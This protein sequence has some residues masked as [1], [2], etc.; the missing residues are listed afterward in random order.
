MMLKD[1]FMNFALLLHDALCPLNVFLLR[2][3]AAIYI[4]FHVLILCRCLDVAVVV[5]FDDI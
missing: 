4:S 3:T 1:M 2:Y 5:Y